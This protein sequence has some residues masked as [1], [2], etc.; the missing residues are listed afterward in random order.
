MA[1]AQLI[2]VRMGNKSYSQIVD[3]EGGGKIMYP[4]MNVIVDNRKQIKK[5][6]EK[7]NKGK[8]IKKGQKRNG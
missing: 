5:D 1:K 8:K 7:S 6:K 3:N 2:N 4:P